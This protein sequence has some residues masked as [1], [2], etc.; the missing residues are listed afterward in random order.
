MRRYGLIL[1]M[2]ALV[3]GLTGCWNGEVITKTTITSVEGAGSRTISVEI[4]KTGVDKPDGSGKVED[5]D[6]F[7]PNGVSAVKD[8]LAAHVPSYVSVS[9]DDDANKHTINLTYSFENFDQFKSKSLALT[10]LS[11]FPVEPFIK[12]YGA[13]GGFNVTLTEDTSLVQAIVENYFGQIYDD[14]TLFDPMY[15]TSDPSKKIAMKDSFRLNSYTTIMGK[16]RKHL[17]LQNMGIRYS[18]KAAGFLLYLQ[19]I[20]IPVTKDMR[21]MSYLPDWLLVD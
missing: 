8:W 10:G 19:K 6:K 17:I 18:L 11:E 5:N 13:P 20:Q 16:Q 2:I 4:Y 14:P 3:G 12:S 21:C 1:V 9:M 15:G 7:F